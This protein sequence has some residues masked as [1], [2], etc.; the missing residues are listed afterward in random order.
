MSDLIGIPLPGKR[1]E[2]VNGLKK[3]L[4]DLSQLILA[5][6]NIPGAE[7]L[8]SPTPKLQPRAENERGR[9]IAVEAGKQ[10]GYGKRVQLIPDG[11]NDPVNHLNRAVTLSHPFGESGALKEDRRMAL[12]MMPE[13]PTEANSMRLSVLGS[14]KAL[15]NS[16]E[17]R[18]EQEQHELLACKSA[19]L[20]GRKPRTALM[21]LLQTK[22][23]IEDTSVPKLCLTGMPI[24]G[25]ALESPFF[26]KW[27]VPSEMTLEE[28]L[29]TAQSR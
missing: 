19:E 24:V 27:E 7:E 1:R 21:E 14:W 9:A 2:S 3:E 26:S 17:V 12:E 5:P 20:L 6:T 16:K 11:L 28:L 13:M 8:Y 29:R 4:Q 18:L 23:R 22:Y 25:R 10:P 15:A